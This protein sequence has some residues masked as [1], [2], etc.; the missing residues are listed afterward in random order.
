MRAEGTV[1]EKA[2]R[3]FLKWFG[4]LKRKGKNWW[5]EECTIGRF[6]KI[7]G[8]NDQAKNGKKNSTS[9]K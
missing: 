1:V 9:G 5:T 2:G 8:K 6:Q 4:H 7:A 3:R